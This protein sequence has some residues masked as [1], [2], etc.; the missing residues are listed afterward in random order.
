[1]GYI[2]SLT[3]DPVQFE[4]FEVGGTAFDFQGR[5]FGTEPVFM[6]GYPRGVI[7]PKVQ[8]VDGE[9]EPAGGQVLNKYTAEFRW[10][11]SQSQQLQAR[12]YLFLD[13]AGAWAG[14]DSY[15]PSNLYRSGGIGVQIFLPIVGML[16][17]NYGYNFDRFTPLEGG[18]TGAPSWSFQ[19]SIGG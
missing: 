9:L 4:R 7:G 5:N 16:E 15:D 13:A 18:Q 1:L 6:R 2:G 8:S 3:G 10:M 14:L 12:P 11:A 19:F 17:F